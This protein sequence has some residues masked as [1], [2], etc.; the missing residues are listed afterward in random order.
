MSCLCNQDCDLNVNIIQH[1]A[2]FGTKLLQLQQCLDDIAAKLALV[3]ERVGDWVPDD[4]SE[5]PDEEEDLEYGTEDEEEDFDEREA[6]G[7]GRNRAS[8][9]SQL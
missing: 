3:E 2:D 9:G 8:L 1:L 7:K 4:A 6:S 5:E